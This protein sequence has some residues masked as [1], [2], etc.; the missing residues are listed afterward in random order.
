V[1][2]F[3]IELRR[4]PTNQPNTTPTFTPPENDDGALVV[5]PAGAYATY[6]DLDGSVRTD[7]ELIVK[8]REMTETPV[9]DGAV[10]D[11]INELIVSEP[12]TEIVK[13]NLDDLNLDPQIKA[14]MNQEFNRVLELYNFNTEAYDIA[15]RWYVD[16]RLYYH[17]VID[18]TM[19]QLGL[20]ELRYIDPR[21]IRKVREIR[22][23]KDPSSLG[24]IISNE[25]E[26]YVFNEKGFNAT[27]M[28]STPGAVSA[29]GAQGL[30]IAKDSIIYVT[31]GLLDKNNKIVLSHLHK[32][33]KI[34][35]QLRSMEDATL[36]YRISRA[37]ERRIFYIDVGNLPKMKA[38][39]YVRDIMT[40]FKNRLVYDSTTG[41]IRDDRKFMTMLE[42]FWLPRREGGRGTEISTLPGGQNLGELADVEYFQKNLFKSLNIPIGRLQSESSGFNLGRAAE[43]TRDEVKFAKFIQRLRLKFSELFLSALRIQLLLK[44]II[45]V[46]DWEYIKQHIRLDFAK[47]N[48][49]SELKE[50]E[51]LSQRA[52]ILATLDPYIGKYYS[53]QWV[54]KHVLYLQD[55][56]IE[57]MQAEIMQERALHPEWFPEF[58][59]VAEQAQNM[60][61]AKKQSQQPKTNK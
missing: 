45:T 12:D 36:I 28:N 39:Q 10:D 42:D 33:L 20:K 38:E 17:A 31:S 3:G 8:Y 43:I 53:H 24:V 30:K 1:E 34:L 49:Y 18:N 59:D 55:D 52:N 46:E 9:V 5:A 41:E 44:G 16:G 40:K 4:R 23:K 22:R 56:E 15:R 29:A 35:N 14:V 48:Y 2:F 26:Y 19:P 7:A 32:A 27:G 57:Q 51:I 37:P 47:D 11:I 25:A 50:S 60:E 21:K 58:M 61:I 13:L 54:Q 6:L